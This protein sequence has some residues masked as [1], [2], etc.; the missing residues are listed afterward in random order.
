MQ[1]AEHLMSFS[2]CGLQHCFWLALGILAVVELGYMLYDT[3]AVREIWFHLQYCTVNTICTVYVYS[4]TVYFVLGEQVLRWS[5]NVVSTLVECKVHAFRAYYIQYFIGCVWNHVLLVEI[6]TNIL[7]DLRKK[8][9]Q[10]DYIKS[11]HTSM[12]N[13]NAGGSIDLLV[14]DKW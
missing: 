6:E 1:K 14:S 8:R 13:T 11:R 2:F 5:K 9:Q 3:S 4:N 10:A 12:R 7:R